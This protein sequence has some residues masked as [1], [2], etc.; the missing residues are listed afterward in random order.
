MEEGVE[1]KAATYMEKKE[2]ESKKRIRNDWATRREMDMLSI[3]HQAIA[4]RGKQFK[5]TVEC[6]PKSKKYSKTK[7]KVR[8]VTRRIAAAERGKKQGMT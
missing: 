8:A 2:A 5:L 7:S 6:K 3:E 4:D 1:Q